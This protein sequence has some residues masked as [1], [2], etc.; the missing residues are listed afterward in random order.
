MRERERERE[1]KRAR[2]RMRKRPRSHARQA[3]IATCAH[4]SSTGLHTVLGTVRFPRGAD[5]T[6]TV[7]VAF[8]TLL[9]TRSLPSKLCKIHFGRLRTRLPVIIKLRDFAL[10]TRFDLC[11]TAARASFVCAL[12]DVLFAGGSSATAG[13][14]SSGSVAAGS[15][16]LPAT[17]LLTRLPSTNAGLFS[18]RPRGAVN[19]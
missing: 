10:R 14:T 19:W 2:E 18:A 17:A 15:S 7:T 3:C 1:R 11:R 13:S 16:A 8:V 12:H 6:Q 9:H 4:R 5:C